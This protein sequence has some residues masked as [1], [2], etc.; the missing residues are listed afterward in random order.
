MS[1]KN[2]KR[3][4]IIQDLV[5]HDREMYFKLYGKELSYSKAL[6]LANEEYD[7]LYD[8]NKSEKKVLDEPNKR[9]SEWGKTVAKLANEFYRDEDGNVTGNYTWGEAWAKGIAK[10][11]KLYGKTKK[12]KSKC[13]GVE[14]N[15]DD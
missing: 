3:Q 4:L 6:K 15:E 10:Y 1:S 11:N 2:S 7:I 5:R 12:P 9:R 14:P 13:S 8:I